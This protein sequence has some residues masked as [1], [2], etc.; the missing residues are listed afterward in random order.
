MI[1]QPD[2]PL[3]WLGAIARYREQA[4]IV[5][6]L[7]GGLVLLLLSLG[8]PWY[9][10]AAI[11]QVVLFPVNDLYSVLPLIIAWQAFKPS[12]AVIG[13]SIS[14]IAPLLYA[15]P[16]NAGSVCALVFVPLGVACA[17]A[18][19]GLIRRYKIFRSVLVKHSEADGQ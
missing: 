11:A 16:N 14:W 9:V 1:L 5:S 8:T 13:T 7:P 19:L 12:I 2:W 6:L 17:L 4:V 3:E 18:Q 15:S 10:S